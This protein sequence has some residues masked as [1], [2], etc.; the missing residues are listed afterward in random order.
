MIRLPDLHH[1]AYSSG[2]GHIKTHR[3]IVRP[4]HSILQP[5]NTALFSHVHGLRTHLSIYCDIHSLKSQR[6]NKSSPNP[7]SSRTLCCSFYNLPPWAHRTCFLSMIQFVRPLLLA[8]IEIPHYMGKCQR[9]DTWPR[10][11]LTETARYK[12][13]NCHGL[14]IEKSDFFFREFAITSGDKKCFY[15]PL[16]NNAVRGMCWDTK[17]GHKYLLFIPLLM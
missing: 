15:G 10:A 13:S 8:Q 2:P 7:S 9:S 16:Q 6:P 17:R 12:F 4:V 14:F 11:Y 5:L 1:H 3:E